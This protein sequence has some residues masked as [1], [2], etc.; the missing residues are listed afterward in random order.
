MRPLANLRC[1]ILLFCLSLALPL[2]AAPASA[3]EGFGLKIATLSP[4][5]TALVD[6]YRSASEE[7]QER[8]EGRVHLK[9]YT[10]GVMGNDAT[11]IRKMRLGQLHGGF[12]GS[13]ALATAYQDYAILSLPMLIRADDE[14]DAVRAALEERLTQGLLD[15]GLISMGMLELGFVYVM[16]NQP[17]ASK[18]DIAATKCWVPEGYDIGRDIFEAFGVAPIPLP[19]PDV[20]TALQTGLIDTVANSPAVTLALQWFTAVTHLTDFPLLYNYGSHVFS[21]KA[22]DKLEPQD[23]EIVAEVLG[24]HMA[25]LNAGSR[26][27]HAQALAALENQGIVFVTPDM[28][29]ATELQSVADAVMDQWVEDGRINGDLLAEVRDI[30]DS[31]RAAR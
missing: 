24:R 5:G 14:A 30:I 13:G 31:V 7:I 9:I 6:A 4:E 2:L 28:D 29:D 17:I 12:V 3:E 25:E 10:G 11:V 8:T 23:Q 19:M 27:T 1:C 15:N 21:Q 16:S 22:W 26:E 18:E 20:L